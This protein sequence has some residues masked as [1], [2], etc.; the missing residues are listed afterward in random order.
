MKKAESER[1]IRY[2]CGV[3]ARENKIPTDGSVDPN[4]YDFHR[5]MELNHPQYLNFKSSTDPMRDMIDWF[6]QE[7]KQDW[8]N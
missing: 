5:W 8:K 7:F 3:W 2:Y 1:M 4:F 6:D